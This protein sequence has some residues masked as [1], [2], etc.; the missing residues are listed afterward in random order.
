VVARLAVA[1]HGEEAVAR[2][3]R[4]RGF[5]VLAR[6]WRCPS[7]EIDLVLRDGEGRLVVFCEVK[8][9]LSPVFGSP[10]EAVTPA[11]ARRLRRLAGRFMAEAGAG[12][13]GRAPARL[14]VDVAAVRP[15]A[16]GAPVVEVVEG[17]C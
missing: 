12:L 17:A 10:L 3:Y 5:E 15:G 16:R 6:N 8:T 13:G 7:G 2:W 4:A 14:R 11:K 9:R 1:R